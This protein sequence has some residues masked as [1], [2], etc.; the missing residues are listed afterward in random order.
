M[1]LTYVAGDPLLTQ[2][3]TLAFGYN[4]RGRAETGALET[5]LLDRFPAAFATFRK[6]CQSGRIQPG[7]IWTW[8]DS[9][10]H[11]AFLVV[12]ASSLGTLRPRFVDSVM[13]LLARDYRLYGFD[14]LAIAPLCDSREWPSLR[15][16]LDYWLSDCLLP[17]TVYEQYVQGVVGEG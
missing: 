2:A 12:R 11:L 14:S 3:Q 13:L 4:A 8:R 6:Q 16:V 10:P 9:N 1:P 15:P 7:A 17:V 5:R